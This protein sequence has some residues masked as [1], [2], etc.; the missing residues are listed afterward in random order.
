MNKQREGSQR[1]LSAAMFPI[2]GQ[3]VKRSLRTSTTN[4]SRI[5]W[6]IHG[7]GRGYRETYEVNYGEKNGIKEGQTKSTLAGRYG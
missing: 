5:L 6:W 7:A 2:Y 3:S 4:C 1:Q